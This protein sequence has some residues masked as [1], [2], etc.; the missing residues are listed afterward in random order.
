MTLYMH[1]TRKHGCAAA[2]FACEAVRCHGCMY[3]Q[4]KYRHP[5][6][7]VTSA[8]LD[9]TRHDSTRHNTLSPACIALATCTH[10]AEVKERKAAKNRRMPRQTRQSKEEGI[11]RTCILSLRLS[12]PL[13]KHLRRRPNNIPS[14][15]RRSCFQHGP[16]FVQRTASL[17]RKRFQVGHRPA[18]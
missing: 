9:T 12:S 3:R 11:H 16:Q 4:S 14:Q 10:D 18:R 5:P 7:E 8:K 13:R 15:N 17:P 6:R 1:T 2:S